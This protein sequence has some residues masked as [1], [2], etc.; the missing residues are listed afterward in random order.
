MQL[1]KFLRRPE[2]EAATGLGRAAIYKAMAAGKFPKA[3]RLVLEGD[4]HPAVAWVEAEI[5]AWQAQRLAER[6]GKRRPANR[7]AR[8]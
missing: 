6:D 2:V 4:E 8:A 1:Q 3:V 5:A 7:R